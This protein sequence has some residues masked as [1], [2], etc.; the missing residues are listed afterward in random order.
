MEVDL[1]DWWVGEHLL[2]GI[3]LVQGRRGG[4]EFPAM[5]ARQLQSISMQGQVR[6]W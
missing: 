3:F 6:D 4:V 2:E 1:L 5:D